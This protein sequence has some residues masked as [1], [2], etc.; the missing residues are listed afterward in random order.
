MK[1]SIA[2]LTYNRLPLLHT[3][4]HSLLDSGHPYRLHL[5][6]GGST[7]GSLEFAREIGGKSIG[8]GKVGGLMNFAIAAALGDKPDIV[9][10][11]AD[12]YAYND[13]WLAD[14]VAFW[15]A[16][17]PE[18]VIAC[19]N[20]EPSYPWNAITER[21]VIGGQAVLIRASVPGSSWSFRAADWPIIGPIADKTGGEDLE[22]CSRLIAQGRKLAAL[23][24]SGHIGEKQ[25]AWGNESWRIAKPLEVA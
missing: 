9:V 20:W 3:T 22:I 23:N 16:A 25:S 21:H 7:D 6:D 14:L 12:D 19:A 18:I 17:P 2:M 8:P 13:G 10:F 5:F 11:S 15:Q 24:L 1:V 4:I